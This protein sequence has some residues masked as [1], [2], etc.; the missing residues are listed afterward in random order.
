[1]SRRLSKPAK[2][3]IKAFH[4]RIMGR[5]LNSVRLGIRTDYRKARL[6]VVRVYNAQTSVRMLLLS[7]MVICLLLAG[8]SDEAA[9]HCNRAIALWKKG[10]YDE[11]ITEFDKAIELNPNYGKAYCY[12]ANAYYDDGRYGRAW[13]DVHTAQ[14]LGYEVAPRFLKT[15]REVSGRER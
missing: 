4:D 12:R 15:L 5:F 10:E 1:M 14:E 11:A 3:S 2:W 13:D 8:C 6:D 9:K 7:G